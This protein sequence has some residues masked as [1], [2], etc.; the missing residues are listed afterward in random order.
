LRQNESMEQS[1]NPTLKSATRPPGGGSPGPSACYR[2][3]IRP[4]R[5]TPTSRGSTCSASTPAAAASRRRCASASAGNRSTQ[6]SGAADAPAP[7][8]AAGRALRMEVQRRK[9]AGPSFW[10]WLKLARMTPA[11]WCGRPC[12]AASAAVKD[13]FTCADAWPSHG[14]T[15][16]PRPS[17]QRSSWPTRAPAW[18]A[19]RTAGIFAGSESGCSSESELP[20]RV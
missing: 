6:S 17:H 4:H 19:T 1:Q 11:E 5:A 18:H 15:S 9:V 8:R 3:R 10:R 2:P 20:I 12:R 14:L 16:G 7:R 13:E